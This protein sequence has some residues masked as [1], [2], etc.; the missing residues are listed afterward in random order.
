MNN[1]KFSLRIISGTSR[2]GEN[3]KTDSDSKQQ[4]NKA[5]IVDAVHR[6]QICSLFA[7]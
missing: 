1:P 3:L 2:A 4:N 7:G 5:R 6:T